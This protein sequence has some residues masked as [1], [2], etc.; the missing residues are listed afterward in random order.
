MPTTCNNHLLL[1]NNSSLTNPVT[2]SYIR[3]PH[4]QPTRAAPPSAKNGGPS[5]SLGWSVGCC[6]VTTPPHLPP[7]PTATP[8]LAATCT[9]LN[10]S[11]AEIWLR[12]GPK[13]HQLINSHLRPHSLDEE[14]MKALTEVYYGASSS[15]RTHRLSPALCKRAKDSNDIVWLTSDSTHELT[16]AISDIATAVACPV[17]NEGLSL[18]LTVIFFSLRQVQMD[19][20]VVEFVFHMR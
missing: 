10:F 11:I 12:T 13:T 20:K 17:C 16:C 14:S 6:P 5:S 7:P 8:V 4:P 3:I 1:L 18:S 15:L 2:P 19:R 9:A